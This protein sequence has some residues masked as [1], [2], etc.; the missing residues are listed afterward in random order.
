MKTPHILMMAAGTG[1]HVFPALAVSEELTQR[2]AVIHWLGTAAG[3]ENALVEPT[4]YAFHPIAMQGLRGKGVARLLKMPLTLLSATMAAMKIIRSNQID[5]VVGFGGYVTAP[6]GIAARMTGTPLIIHEQN[7][8]AG[9]SNRYLA[10]MATKVLQAFE[11]T[12]ANSQTSD[13][14][15]TVGNPVRNAITGVAPPTSRYDV[16]DSSPLRLLVVGGSLGAQVLNTNVPKA[17]AM[18]DKAFEV[19]HQCGRHNEQATQA[20]YDSEDLSQHKTQVQPF[21]NDMAAAYNWADMIVCRAGALTVT[22]IQNVGIPAIFVPLPHAVDDHQTANAR[23]LTDHGAAILLPQSELTPERLCAELT[24]LDRV[25]CLQM[26][27][28]GHA[29]AN[30]S[31][32]QQVADIIWQHL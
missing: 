31:A 27:E 6:G 2:G 26:A 14:L 12:F 3:M 11:D 23:A 15:E 10:K 8:I 32:T 7:A 13:K 30:R 21:I 1:G 16:N 19:R 25:T 5:M 9:M 17:L 4:G 24:T 18:M 20:A 22:E 29:L 28:K